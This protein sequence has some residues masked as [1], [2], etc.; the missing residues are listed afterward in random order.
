[1]GRV[2]AVFFIL[3]LFGIVFYIFKPSPIDPLA[4][5][6][7]EPP[8]MEGAY[9]S[10]SLLLK[11]ELIGLGKLQGPEDMEV[12]DQGNIYSADGNGTFYLALFTVRN[13]L[14]DRI[15]H[16][17]PALKSLISKLPRFFWPKAQ[18][19]GFV[20]LLDE[21]ATPLRS[22]QEPTGEHLKA[23]TSVKYKNG[24]LYL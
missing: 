6:P 10:N 12:D 13:P 16:P 14:M 17:R 15:F 21:N 4:Y 18:P 1:M 5:F 3:S 9:T 23:I 8:P 7:P 19:Y 24:F 22:F 11:A 2:L 20:L